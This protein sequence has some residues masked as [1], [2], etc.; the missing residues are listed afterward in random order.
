MASTAHD[1]PEMM[2]EH[3]DSEEELQQKVD[4]LAEMVR[5][6]QHFVAFT[7][8]GIST[9]AGI[10]DFRGPDGKWT[11]QAQGKE[12]LKG[13]SVVEAFPTPTHMALLELYNRGV[14]KYL[15]S[16][17][18]DGL[19]RR[20][21]FPAAAISELHGNGWVEICESCG[22]QHFRDFKCTRFMRPGGPKLP[23][24]HFTG[25]FCHCGGRL[26]NS[27]I[28]FGQSLPQ[29][30]L[31]LAATHSNQA[32]LHLALGSSLTVSP[33]N[34][35]PE[36]TA[37]NGGK[38]V[39]VNLQKTPLDKHATMHIFAKTDLVMGM[40]MER[41]GIQIPTFQLLRRVIVGKRTQS[42]MEVYVRAVDIHEPSIPTDHVHA[43]EWDIAG[44]S[45]DFPD[46]K[47]HR[48]RPRADVAE[49]VPTLM[50]RGHYREPP[51][52]VP[53]SLGAALAVNVLLAYD[54]YRLSWACLSK[55]ELP[56]GQVPTPGDL[57]GGCIPDYGESH[58]EYC[59]KKAQQSRNCS[60]EEAAKLID[61]RVAESIRAAKGAASRPEAKAKDYPAARP[62]DEPVSV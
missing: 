60:D 19:H 21:G 41:L 58:R 47:E 37:R 15:I 10:P 8:A 2:Q 55:E 25:R 27:T 28:D 61:T 18:C 35:Q 4:R 50:W 57:Q 11:R 12:A 30:P 56:D 22:Q 24:D 1:D 32:D 7:G 16:Q 40:L 43:V 36:I 44:P 49:V 9:S 14:L 20:S 34:A 38:L 23:T 62:G 6:S 3:Y 48:M 45:K 17:N 33:A 52:P 53:V 13:V 5:E 42:Q 54:P 26:L 46:K 29:K 31:T 59:I 51:T 39:I